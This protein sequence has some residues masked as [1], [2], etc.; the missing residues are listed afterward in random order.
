MEIIWRPS[1]V[2]DIEHAR[3]SIAQFNPTA[4]TRVFG[5]I[6][7]TVRALAGSPESGR[8]GRVAGTREFLAP[9]T[10]Y[11]IAYTVIDDQLVVLAVLHHAQQ[12]PEAF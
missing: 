7:T 1:A 6:R 9:R 4:A 2:E 12:W 8:P 5:A 3:H 11:L 10:P